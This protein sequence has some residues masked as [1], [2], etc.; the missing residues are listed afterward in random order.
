MLHGNNLM[1]IDTIRG[2]LQDEDFIPL[3]LEILY[4]SDWV[5]IVL[6]SD[7][8]FG[9]DSRLCNLFP[10]RSRSKPSQDNLLESGSVTRTKKRPDIENRADIIE[11]KYFHLKKRLKLIFDTFKE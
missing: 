3:F 11:K 7:K 5:L 2:L 10:R 8:V 1:K 6:P 4:I 9:S